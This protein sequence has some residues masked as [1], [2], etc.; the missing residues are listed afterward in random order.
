MKYVNFTIFLFVIIFVFGGCLTN[1][2]VVF[3]ENLPAT[4][5][6]TVYWC[7]TGNFVHP[8]T[9]NGV[10]V[11]WNIGSMGFYPIIIPAGETTFELEG[12]TASG[13]GYITYKYY[14]TG[15]SFS[16]NFAK[17]EEYT[18]Y[19]IGRSLTIHSG[20]SYSND[21]ILKKVEIDWESR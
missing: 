21:T 13:G 2:P 11:N 20:K 18:V 16:Y 6:T 8:V 4:E 5:A 3:D 12:Y 15:I 19:F 1:K 7:G 17:G 14:Y 10:T 9:Y